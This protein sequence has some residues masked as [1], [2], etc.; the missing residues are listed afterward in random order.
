MVDSSILWDYTFGHWTNFGSINNVFQGL[1]SGITGAVRDDSNINW[2]FK[3]IILKLI[4]E[5][6]GLK[7]KIFYLKEIAFGLIKTKN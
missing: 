4:S 5:N 2:F 6:N 1:E 7:I 3:G